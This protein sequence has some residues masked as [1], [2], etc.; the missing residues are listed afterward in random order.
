MDYM[1]ITID[2]LVKDAK[3]RGAEAMNTLK[4]LVNSTKINKY[5]EEKPLS[6]IAV[7]RA[8]MNKYY[9]ESIPQAK[10]KA[11]TMKELVLAM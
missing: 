5:G 11:P 7:K 10:A 4:E 6:Y 2:D 1:N 8:Y 3:A 9:P